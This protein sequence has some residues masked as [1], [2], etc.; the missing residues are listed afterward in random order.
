MRKH[1]KR[2]KM[3]YDEIGRCRPIKGKTQTRKRCLPKDIYNRI[4]NRTAIPC[5]PGED[6]CILDHTQGLT[7]EE[8]DGL[9]KAYLRPRFPKGWESDP[10]DWLDNFNIQDVMSQYQEANPWFKFMGVFPIDFLVQNPSI[11]DQKQCL[12]PELCGLKISDER[13]NGV[14]A[15]GAIFNLDPHYKGGSPWVG[16]YCCLTGSKPWCAYFD[17]YGMDVPNYISIFMRA[18][19]SQDKRIR[20]MY[21]ARRFQYGN[22]EC[23][24]YSMYFL[25]C[26]MNGIKFSDFCKDSVS[27]KF[28]LGLRKIL[29]SK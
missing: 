18:L 2:R 23:G 4:P 29:F 17:S 24:M 12:H 19:C 7:V 10:D 15:I 6:H 13:A 27:D 28:M 22:S 20:L 25:I 5:G 3:T 11:K 9:R 14:R 8:K 16:L 1:S 26:M 21:N